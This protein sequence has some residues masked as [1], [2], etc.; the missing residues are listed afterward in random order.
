MR[1]LTLT[2]VY[3]PLGYSGH[4]ERCRQT[5]Q[6]LARRG[7]QVQVLTS[8][9]RLPPIGVSGEKG[10]FRDCHLHPEV[11]D[12]SLLGNSYK[13]TFAHERYNAESL[14]YRLRRF[15]PNAVY[16][17]N[18]HGLSKS[19]L[20]RLRKR[21]F[22]VV[23]DLHAEWLLPEQFNR[24]PWYR[25]WYENRSKRSKLYRGAIRILGRARGVI[26]QLP[27][28]K[29]E[30]LDLSGGYVVSEW[31]RQQLVDGGLRRAESLP[32]LHPAIAI[33]KLSPKGSFKARRHFAWAGRLS[34]DKGVDIAVD[35]VGLLKKWGIKVSLDIF[36]EGEP[37]ERKAKRERIEAAGLID[38][39]TMRG[40][41]PGEL[42]DYY[43]RY[44]AL[45]YTN[46]QGEPFSMT[47]LEAMLSKLPCIVS[48]IGGNRELLEDGANAML[49]RPGDAVALADT[50]G[51]FVE[52]AD[53]GQP[54]AEHSI[55]SLQE[56]QSL[57]T[58]CD[59]AE[60]LLAGRG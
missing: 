51:Q 5:V 11:S 38:Q 4:D 49:F 59:R 47:V 12:T 26:G 7:H 19:L 37:S 6:C 50:M 35:A 30:E 28:G 2:S 18:M 54:L 31:L 3:P 34:E 20:F 36:G 10:V 40:I 53:A 22:R 57:D 48:D 24:D 55:E 33:S 41:R 1:I 52:R 45:L 29:A 14:E 46:R 56:S 44:D 39:V 9:H 15:K 23:Y 60:R 43:A 58:F 32:V 13:A 27:I 21:E 42:A 8:D 16:V 25:W 17:W